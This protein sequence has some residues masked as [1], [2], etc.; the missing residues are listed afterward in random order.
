MVLE[1]RLFLVLIAIFFLPGAA[2]LT[3][4]DAWRRWPGL[5]RYVMAIGLSI[6]FF[7]LLYYTLRFWV[8]AARLGSAALAVILLISA[9]FV[10]RGLWRYGLELVRIG[11]LEWVA[12]GVFLLTLA[13]RLW[14]AHALPFPAWSDSLHH[15][16]L[17]QLTVDQGQ[18]P[19]GM[20]PYY[21]VDFGMYH[22]GLYALAAPVTQLAQAPAPLAL[23]W[24]A[25]FLNAASVLGIYLALDRYSGRVGA[26]TGAAVVGLF[27]VHPAFYANWGRFTQVAGQAV[28]LIAW[29]AAVEAVRAWGGRPV[30]SPP[31]PP[32]LGGEDGRHH[33]EE[34][35]QPRSTLPQDWG[36]GGRTPDQ[37]FP[38]I[39][40]RGA[41]PQINPSPGLGAGGPTRLLWESILAA[42]LTAGVFLLHFRVAAFYVLLLFISMVHLLWT[43]RSDRRQLRDILI[44]MLAVG[45]LSLFL[46]LPTLWEALNSFIAK[47]GAIKNVEISSEDRAASIQNYFVFP[48]SSVPYLVAPRWLLM[49]TVIA[50]LIGLIRRSKLVIIAL[51]WTILL[52]LL[53]NAYLTG[54]RVLS[55]TNLGAILIMLYMPMGLIIGAAVQEVLTLLPTSRRS[56]VGAVVAVGI[57]LFGVWGARERATDVEAYRHFVKPADLTAMEWIDENIPDDATFAINTYFWLPRAPHGVDAGYWIPYLT[58][59]ETTAPA[60][61]IPGEAE[62]ALTDRFIE[63]S[64]LAEQ[65]ESELDPLSKLYDMNIRYIYIGSVGDFSGPGLQL[66]FLRQSKRVKV[67]YEQDGVTIL[68]IEN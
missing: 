6:A 29:V 66:D 44:G 14:F 68:E 64:H 17:T 26:I 41:E 36:P 33:A 5:Q 15:V 51:I 27:S 59:R 25:Q 21:P 63:R 9:G 40:R 57:L 46:I 32:T 43:A 31:S 13:S 38:R 42:A 47:L 20:Q 11:G 4:G 16:M 52:Y 56:Q 65:L 60:M 30:T 53:G 3:I 50:A 58:G 35:G 7:P 18:L 19:T 22:L 39:G 12:V 55:I 8:P 45:A 23:L 48:W 67:L 62:Q 54:I 34:D 37:P 24:T 2:L 28:L 1:L 61:I 10:V 49:T